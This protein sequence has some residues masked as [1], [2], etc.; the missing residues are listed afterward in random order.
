[1]RR[2]LLRL[3]PRAWRRRYG[4]EFADLLARHPLTPAGIV[5]VARGALDAHRRHRR[6]GQEGTMATLARRAAPLGAGLVAFA[7]GV[8]LANL[9]LGRLLGLVAWAFG[10]PSL[11]RTGRPGPLDAPWVLPA[12]TA[13]AVALALLTAGTAARWTWGRLAR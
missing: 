4:E 11:L 9:A 12:M 3:Y 1:M 6:Q 7:C 2:W 13:A 5:D 8:V 10:W